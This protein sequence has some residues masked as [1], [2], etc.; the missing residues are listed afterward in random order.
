MRAFALMLG[1]SLVYCLGCHSD[2]RPAKSLD[3]AEAASS[4]AS[5]S[6]SDTIPVEGVY[7]DVTY[8]EDAGDVVG[9]EIV[10]RHS[11]TGFVASFQRAEGAPLMRHTVAATVSGPELRFTL[12]PD[13]GMQVQGDSRTP[14]ELSPA[15]T[16][17]GHVNRWGLIGRIEGARD[18]LALPRKP[19][20]YFDEQP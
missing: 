19:R 15:Q 18:T 7:S 3:G 9:T 14:V 6:V 16:F 20:A 5:V 10:V 13:S 12:P 4:T 8:I 2:N 1:I 17:V 11:G